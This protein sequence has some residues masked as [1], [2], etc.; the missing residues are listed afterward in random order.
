MTGIIEIR[1]K[2]GTNALFVSKAIVLR[3]LVTHLLMQ[4][5]PR[6][7]SWLTAPVRHLRPALGR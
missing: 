2:C 5:I 6:L 7:N 4:Q 1:G 3:R